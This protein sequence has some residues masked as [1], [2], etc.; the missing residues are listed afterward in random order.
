MK[1]KHCFISNFRNMLNTYDPVQ[2]LRID[3]IINDSTICNLESK[4]K[5]CYFNLWNN[6][7]N[8]SIKLSFYKT[9]KEYYEEE[10]YLTTLNNIKERQQLTQLRISNHKLAIETGRYTRPKTP[11]HQRFC[12][13]CNNGTIETE[14]H[15]IS[16]CQAYSNIRLEFQSKLE[17][18]IDFSTNYITKLMK[19]ADDNV[20]FYLSKFISKCF[21]HRKEKLSEV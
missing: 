5:T 16:D 20:I 1:N 18:K 17:G 12:L 3:N 4:M 21:N 9:F 11:Q 2:P 14:E 8:N 19:S 13:L 7:L 15:M 6:I 10:K